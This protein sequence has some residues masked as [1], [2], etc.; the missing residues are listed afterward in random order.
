DPAGV[1]GAQLR[2]LM[3]KMHDATEL[4]LLDRKGTLIGSSS[5]HGGELSLNPQAAQRGLRQP[6]LHGPYIDQRTQQLGPS[7]SDFHDAGTLMFYQPLQH[8]GE[9]LG[10][11]CARIPNDVLGDLIQR[12]AGHVYHESGD[13]YI[14]MVESRFDP[15]IEH[16]RA[17]SRSR[18]EDSTF[19]HGDNL[20]DGIR[21]S[22]GSLRVRNPTEFELRCTAPAMGV[23]HPCVRETIRQG[24]NLFVTYPGY[25]D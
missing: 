7:T 23:L 21:T 4:M 11:L 2:Q 22:W 1:A 18:F 17:L 20:K 24:S 13:N 3:A 19:S 14:F 5:D 8:D 10:C 9:I 6:F 16:G 15:S 25:S 12:E